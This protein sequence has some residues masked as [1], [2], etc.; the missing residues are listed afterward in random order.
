MR[1]HAG[2][3]VAGDAVNDAVAVDDPDRVIVAVSDIERVVGPGRQP[4]D[5]QEPRID[6]R[7]AITGIA[8]AWPTLP[9]P[10]TIC[11]VPSS[12][13]FRTRWLDSET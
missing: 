2:G 7:P 13:I 12:A 5:R 8:V 4:P 3:A 1:A 9:P 6:G 10:A 11:T